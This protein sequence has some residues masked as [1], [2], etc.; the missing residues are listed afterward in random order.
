[1][2]AL[3]L[4]NVV[5]AVQDASDADA[6]VLATL[7]DLLLGDAGPPEETRAGA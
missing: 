5:E 3:S 7:V 1:M 2:T 4:W 6:E